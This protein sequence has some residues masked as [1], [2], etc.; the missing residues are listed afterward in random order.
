MRV[1]GLTGSRWRVLIPEVTLEA[2]AEFYEMLTKK[3]RLVK[4]QVKSAARNKPGIFEAFSIRFRS[5]PSHLTVKLL[6]LY[7]L[8]RVANCRVLADTVTIIHKKWGLL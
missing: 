1:L 2:G 8:C 6:V 7:F 4:I 3:V 5:D